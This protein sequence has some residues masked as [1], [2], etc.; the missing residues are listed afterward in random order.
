L[1]IFKGFPNIIEVIGR[2]QKGAGRAVKRD[3]TR[4]VGD[5]LRGVLKGLGLEG[6][7]E[8]GR[9]REQWPRIVGEAIARKSKPQEVRGATLIVEV[10][11]NVWMNEIQFHRGEIVRKIHEEFPMLKIQDI[12]LKLERER[13][14]E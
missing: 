13:E 2:E 3:S 14:R 9:L 8:E 4:R 10:E 1:F 6:K 5:L 12:R 11:N 7:L